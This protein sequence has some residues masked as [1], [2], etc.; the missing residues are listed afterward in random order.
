MKPKNLMTQMKDK[1]EGF[2]ILEEL[3]DHEDVQDVYN[4]NTETI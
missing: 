1:Q 3:E 4:N 2:V